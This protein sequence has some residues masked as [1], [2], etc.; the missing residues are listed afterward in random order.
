MVCF[1]GHFCPYS[2]S[3]CKFLGQGSFKRCKSNNLILIFLTISGHN[4]S[5]FSSPL[6]NLL[7][8]KITRFRVMS[9]TAYYLSLLSFWVW[10]L[11]A[12]SAFPGNLLGMHTLRPPSHSCIR[13]WECTSPR[14]SDARSGWRTWSKTM[15]AYLVYCA[16]QMLLFFPNWRKDSPPAK[17]LQLALW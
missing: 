17:R 9:N 12:A 7:Q 13:N 16:S 1:L 6:V 15:Q 4:R 2:F 5:A 11:S 10:S 3:L 14:D 8:K